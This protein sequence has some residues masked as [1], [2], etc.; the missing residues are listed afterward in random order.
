MRMDY[1]MFSF[2]KFT[3]KVLVKIAISAKFC[4]WTE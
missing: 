3:R 4:K 1:L 2:Q